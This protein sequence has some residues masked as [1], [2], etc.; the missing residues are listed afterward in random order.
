MMSLDKKIGI[1]LLFATALFFVVYIFNNE[2]S[3][4]EMVEEDFKVFPIEHASFSMKLGDVE[5]LNDPVGK[6]ELYERYKN[7]DLILFGSDKVDHFNV[8]LLEEIVSNKTMIIAP[9]FVVDTLPEDLQKQTVAMGS[10]DV[11]HVLGIEI[12][13]IPAYELSELQSENTGVASLGNGYLLTK[14]DF[15]V[16]IAGDTEDVPEMRTLEDIDVAFIPMSLPD[17]MDVDVAADAVLDFSP[18][19]V[20]PY[21]YLGQSGLSDVEE[22]TRLVKAANSDI[23]IVELDWYLGL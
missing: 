14:D 2:T 4:D 20:Y 11:H 1:V 22:F 23:E 9:A 21:H 18:V 10:G 12:K 3:D 15:S 16:Y 5:I 13:V 7:P 19:T 17:T 6:L 8:E